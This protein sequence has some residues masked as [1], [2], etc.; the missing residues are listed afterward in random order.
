MKA[1]RGSAILVMGVVLSMAGTANAAQPQN[2]LI[3][4]GETRVIGPAENWGSSDSILTYEASDFELFFG[5]FGGID[6]IGARFCGGGTCGWLGGL[7]LP[8]G[9]ILSSVELDACDSDAAA[10]VQVAVFRS[11]KAGGALTNLT[12]FGGTGIMATPGCSVFSLN[13]TTPET[14]NNLNNNYFIDVLSGATSATSFKAVRVT[15]RLQV[16][17][18]P[19]VASFPNDVPTTNPFFRFVEAMAASG[20]TGGCGPGSFCPD[21]PVT[22]GQLSVFLSVALGLHFPN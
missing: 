11:V 17:P 16:S 8:A 22:R 13:L 19:A 4:N 14:I 9:A 3:S 5:T 18:A 2:Q 20:L 12:G 15:Y 6:G 10:Q 1:S 7:R 21:S